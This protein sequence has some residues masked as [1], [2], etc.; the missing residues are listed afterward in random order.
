MGHEVDGFPDACDVEQNLHFDAIMRE[1]GMKVIKEHPWR[2]AA[3]ALGRP[4]RLWF[5]YQMQHVKRPALEMAMRITT[6]S[7][8]SLFLFGAF[9]LWRRTERGWV[10][11]SVCLFLSLSHLF[12]F[13]SSRYS[14]PGKGFYVMAIA[15]LLV[16]G[17]R[18]RRALVRGQW[19]DLEW[20]G[21][22]PRTE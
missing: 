7:L 11:M 19:R 2:T 9:Q 8:L 12:L 15:Y 21:R 5:S 13:V 16:A 18:N 14:Q 4:V 10:A 17:W 22:A 6:L 1:K 3:L 20:P